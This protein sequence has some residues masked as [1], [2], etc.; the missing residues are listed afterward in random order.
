[1]RGA[2]GPRGCA[3]GRRRCCQK[4]A[5]GSSHP[6]GRV[7]ALGGLGL[8]RTAPANS[9]SWG[10][11]SKD[12][13]SPGP[14]GPLRGALKLSQGDASCINSA[15]P[16]HK[17]FS[18]T[19]PTLGSGAQFFVSTDLGFSGAERARRRSR[20]LHAA[21]S[22]HGSPHKVKDGGPNRPRPPRTRGL[23]AVTTAPPDSSAIGD[24]PAPFAFSNPAPRTAWLPVNT[25]VI[26]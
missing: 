6:I 13:F 4:A 14:T 20:A 3:E 26:S 9:A 17:R 15:Y 7:A 5:R 16:T 11:G 24:N 8:R 1:M 21:A 10:F 22:V 19:V 23:W 2:A 25:L 18:G 12:S